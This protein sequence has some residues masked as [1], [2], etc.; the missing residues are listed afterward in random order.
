MKIAII[1][2]GYFP[3]PATKGGAVE[4][5]IENLINENETAKEKLEFTIFSTYEKNAV[6]SSKKYL[7]SHFYFIKTP[8]FFSF[9]DKCIYFTAKLLRCKKISSYRYILKRLH[10]IKKVSK[11]INQE[12][13]DLLVLENHVTLFSVLKY[14]NN[15][16]MY[17]RKYCYHIHNVINK[18]YNNS[19]YFQNCPLFIGVSNYVNCAVKSKHTLKGNF[20]ILKNRVNE[21]KFQSFLKENEKQL[22]REKLNIPI[23]G[24]IILFTGRLS[25][26]KGICELLESFNLLDNENCYLVIVG[27]Q[28]FGSG[29]KNSFDNYLLKL[30]KIK[31]DK[32]RFTGY[33]DYDEIWKYY[34]LADIVVLPSIWDDPA[35]L[36]VIEAIQTSSAIITTYSGGIPE[37]ITED[38][39]IILKIDDNLVK[40]LTS[41]MCRL[42][43]NPS[44][45]FYLKEQTKKIACGLSLESYYVEFKNIIKEFVGE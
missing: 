20:V 39:A 16:D 36:T 15:Y 6:A 13:F 31:E 25:Y 12:K 2:S 27:S 17:K 8:S 34:V 23:G 28:Y 9:L 19:F 7:S 42:L 40:N 14:K 43:D 45:L 24:Q 29:I 33:V 3:V 37:Y 41:S 32:I 38:S 4:N 21:K 30:S 22:L 18:L 10:Y 44:E 5:I 11:Q 26:E 1:N 35:P